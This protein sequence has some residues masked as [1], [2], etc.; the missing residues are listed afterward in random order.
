MIPALALALACEGPTGKHRRPDPEGTETAATT[1]AV[2]VYPVVLDEAPGTD[3]CPPALSGGGRRLAGD[4]DLET[5]SWSDVYSGVLTKDSGLFGGTLGD[6]GDIT[7]DGIPDLA[8]G[9]DAEGWGVDF[10]TIYFVPSPV[11][12]GQQDA[13]SVGTPFRQG[14]PEDVDYWSTTGGSFASLPDLTGDGL[15]ELVVANE[16]AGSLQAKAGS[17]AVYVFASPGG[18]P[19]THT[20]VQDARTT[21]ESADA[22]WFGATIA[23]GDLDGDEQ[24]DLVVSNRRIQEE[25][26][27]YSGGRSS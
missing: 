1:T 14:R 8:I 10:G 6:V 4:V 19:G 21:I 20:P 13:G 2:P 5:E 17:G 22:P 23:V 15:P 16:S 25:D 3:Q 11:L 26:G 27:R 7:G 12:P 9:A 18:L 24:A